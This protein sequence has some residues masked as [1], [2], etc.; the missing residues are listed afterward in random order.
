MITYEIY[1]RVRQL[2]REGVLSYAQIA[3][4]LNLHPDTVSKYAALEPKS[5]SSPKRSK[6]ALYPH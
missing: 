2:H 5:R 4:E 3:Q 6:I 1:C